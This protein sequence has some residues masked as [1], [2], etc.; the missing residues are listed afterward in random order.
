MNSRAVGPRV[1]FFRVM[2]RFQLVEYDQPR[3]GAGLE[4]LA[5]TVPDS[6]RELP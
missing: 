3:V 6:A 1:R 5:G 2:S 4:R